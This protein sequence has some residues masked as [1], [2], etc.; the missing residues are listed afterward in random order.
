MTC[1]GRFRSVLGFGLLIGA[2][3]SACGS[4]KTESAPN[5]AG[6]TSGVGS[7]AGAAGNPGGGSKGEQTSGGASLMPR[8]AGGAPDTS[9]AT[10]T[11]GAAPSGGAPNGGAMDAGTSREGEKGGSAP[12]ARGGGTTSS[13]ADHGGRTMVAGSGGTSS[14]GGSSSANQSGGTPQLATP[15]IPARPRPTVETES[16]SLGALADIAD[17]SAIYANPSAPELSVVLA[18]NKDDSAGGIAVFDMQGKLLQLRKEGKIGNVD[19]REGFSLGG[20]TIVLVGANNRTHDS[21]QFWRL[22]PST[23]QLSNPI[24]EAKTSNA[25]NYG[26]CLY[27]SAATGKFYAFVTQE[28][29]ASVIEQYELTESGGRLMASK[30]RAFEVG[31]ITEGCVADDE[32][33]RLYVAQEDVAIWRYDAEPS[34]GSQ[35]T[36]VA[37]VGDGHLVADLEGLGLAK[38]AGTSGYLV[39][40]VQSESRFA[41]YDRESNA[42][43]RG[44]SIS[45]N[46]DI[47]APDQTD[48]LDISTVNLGPGFPHGALIVH[49]GENANG[50]TSNLKYIPLE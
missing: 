18:D 47:D 33:G 27:H 1:T 46:A 23:R 38:G 3:H 45:A 41:I 37:S 39:V 49:D 44:F 29:G 25:P 32:L 16:F 14:T 34:G 22:D 4:T 43:L 9:A 19:L 11:G 17:D 12:V 42:Y 50:A 48:G 10:E 6:S 8:S 13:S 35:R 20:Q 2:F 36:R 7:I 24:G 26:F 31:S 28:T 15:Q 40:S 5:R 30:V 21:I